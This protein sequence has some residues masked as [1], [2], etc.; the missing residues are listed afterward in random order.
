[1]SAD[2]STNKQV[3]PDRK[4]FLLGVIALLILLAFGL[5]IQLPGRSGGQL[6]ENTPFPSAG[7][8]P[9]PENTPLPSETP[10]PQTASAWTEIDAGEGPALIWRKVHLGGSTPPVVFGAN[11]LFDGER[12]Y[13]ESNGH[14]FWVSNDGEAWSETGLRVPSSGGLLVSGPS[15]A[16][17]WQGKLVAVT[18]NEIFT[19][20]AEAS[21][22]LRFSA[23]FS[24]ENLT[25]IR[26]QVVAGHQG[27]LVAYSTLAQNQLHAL[28]VYA[29]ADG[30]D[31]TEVDI[32]SF[33]SRQFGRIAAFEAGFIYRERHGLWYS[34]DGLVWEEW[35][36]TSP[37]ARDRIPGGLTA[38]Q[39]RVLAYPDSAFTGPSA[40]LEPYTIFDAKGMHT[41]PESGLPPLPGTYV[42]FGG[43]LST[44]PIGIVAAFGFAPGNE[45]PA[46]CCSDDQLAGVV[47]FSP[48]GVTWT[49]RKL[50]A[51]ILSVMGT[52]VGK[53]RVLLTVHEPE[54]IERQPG[55]INLW[56]GL[57]EED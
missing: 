53:D 16:A 22:L 12:F 44:G 29:S 30:R 55:D 36:Q 46:Q 37:A 47:E 27:F 56:I 21:A 26:F 52:A 42:G 35:F 48:D 17:A 41:L 54:G 49:R 15:E 13:A 32:S 40:S 6:P 50:P 4:V 43:N 7:P 3:K 51:D 23:T 28:A 39:G 5:I 33:A 11:L 57:L 2:K 34:P 31:W 14:Q 1:M 10:T 45:P 9:S 19:W 38:W 20:D 25:D 18:G 24:R 8:S